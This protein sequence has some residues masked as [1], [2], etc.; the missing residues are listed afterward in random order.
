M[1]KSLR[2]CSKSQLESLNKQM[3]SSPIPFINAVARTILSLST[4]LLSRCNQFQT[5]YISLHLWLDYTL[6]AKKQIHGNK[7][8]LLSAKHSSFPN[9]STMLGSLSVLPTAGMTCLS[10]IILWR[11]SKQERHEQS[12]N[13]NL[14]K[15]GSF[16]K[17]GWKEQF[18]TGR[19]SWPNTA[20][21]VLH[22]SR[23]CRLHQQ[24]DSC[25]S[26]VFNSLRL[27]YTSKYLFWHFHPDFIHTNGSVQYPCTKLLRHYEGK[28]LKLFFKVQQAEKDGVKWFLV[29][30][31]SFSFTFQRKLLNNAIICLEA[32]GNTSLRSQCPSA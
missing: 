6:H 1:P 27:C 22:L 32:L 2:H 24:T 28:L 11:I 3:K 19:R 16:L 26:V 20:D 5:F 31:L 8:K 30:V 17:S 4:L 29:L 13:P 12:L 23:W 25:F 15:L 9:G 14:Q 10:P 21:N 18:K 7:C